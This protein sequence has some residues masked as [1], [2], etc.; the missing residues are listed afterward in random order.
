MAGSSKVLRKNRLA[1]AASRLAV[2]RKLM[3]WPVESTARYRYR[4]RPLIRSRVRGGAQ[5]ER[6]RWPPSDAQ[7]AR[8]V[9]PHAAFTKNPC[10]VGAL[11]GGGSVGC[12]FLICRQKYLTIW[13]RYSKPHGLTSRCYRWL[14]PPFDR[15]A[16]AGRLEDEN[17]HWAGVQTGSRPAARTGV[18]EKEGT[19]WPCAGPSL[20]SR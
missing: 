4:S 13:G 7:T 10:R 19:G 17:K 12:T 3:V 1:A 18:G 6:S 15:H 11:E 5:F 20:V 9:F 2:S 14:D 16:P 8:A